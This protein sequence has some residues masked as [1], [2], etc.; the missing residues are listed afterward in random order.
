[1]QLNTTGFTPAQHVP[2]SGGFIDPQKVAAGFGVTEGMRIADFGSGAGFFA[3]II[4]KMLGD[5]G[6]VTAVDVMNNALDTLRAKAK[7]EGLSN[8][9]TVR[10]NLEVLGS[11]GLSN[12]SQDM[13]I[14]ANILFQN[15][16]KPSI[17]DESKRV[18]KPGG[19]IVVIDWRK[20]TGGFGP[21]DDLRTDQEEMRQMILNH[22]FGHI[23]DIDAGLFHYGMTF[24]KI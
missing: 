9:E 22:G 17:I 2:G 12:E 16:N 6:V 23:S 8:I 3:I 15:K 13:A 24:K 1:M 11:S 19:I 21:P 14:L 4:A 20:G 7:M 5:S 10:S 18:L